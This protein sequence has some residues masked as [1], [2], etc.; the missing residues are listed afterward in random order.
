M[1]DRTGE[2][3]EDRVGEVYIVLGPPRRWP[4]GGSPC[5]FH[6]V[7]ALHEGRVSNLTDKEGR[8]LEDRE[9]WTRL[10]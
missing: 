5:A 4:H 7:W 8:L 2:V 9:G 1:R 3:W 10:A 6:A